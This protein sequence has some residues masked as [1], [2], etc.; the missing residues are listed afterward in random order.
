[1][2]RKHDVECRKPPNTCDAKEEARLR[3]KGLS[4]R[5]GPWQVQQLLPAPLPAEFY[6]H[7]GQWGTELLLAKIKIAMIAQ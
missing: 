6:S 5:Q 7:L 2:L 3:E 1:M 4:R